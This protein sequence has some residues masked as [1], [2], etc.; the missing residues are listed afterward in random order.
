MGRHSLSPGGGKGIQFRKQLRN[1]IHI[2]F[3]AD[4]ADMRIMLRLPDQMLTA[5]E[6][7]FEPNVSDRSGKVGARVG[8]GIQM[9]FELGKQIIEQMLLMRR[10]RRPLAA[11]VQHATRAFGVFAG[12]IRS[13]A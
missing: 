10:E 2:G 1:T 8:A 7:H 13:S 4:D 9:H 5:A 12:H 6:S 3:S 11:A